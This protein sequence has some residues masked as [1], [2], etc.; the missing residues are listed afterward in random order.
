MS[1][2]VRPVLLDAARGQDHQR[3]AF[4]LPGDL[5]LGQIDEVATG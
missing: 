2:P 5:G 3:V 4:E 1:V